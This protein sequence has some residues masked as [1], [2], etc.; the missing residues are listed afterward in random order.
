MVKI[1]YLLFSFIIIVIFF[2]LLESA[3]YFYYRFVYDK[4][5]FLTFNAANLYYKDVGNLLERRN[6]EGRED[7]WF[8]PFFPTRYYR[9]D[10]SYAGKMIEYKKSK[11]T[12]R[13]FSYGGSCTAGSPWGHRASFS[14]F[15]NDELNRIKRYGKVEIMN[16]GMGGIGSS[17]VLALVNETIK[18]KPDILLI[19]CGHNEC[20]DNYVHLKKANNKV[21]KFD[22][23]MR[24]RSYL[25]KVGHLMMNRL[26]DG[27]IPRSDLLNPK[28]RP[29]SQDAIY[30]T[31]HRK[32]FAAQ[33][34]RNMRNIADIASR[35]N[36]S[37]VF[38][39]QPS[40]FFFEPEFY[41]ADDDISINLRRAKQMIDEDRYSEA[42][43]YIAAIFAKDKEASMAHYYNGLVYLNEKEYGNAR[44]AFLKA[45]EYDQKPQRA[46][47]EYREIL[48]KLA[49]PKKG[50]YFVD[51]K[52]KFY[53]YLDDGL[54]DGRLIIDIVHPT[55]KGQKIIARAIL[56]DYFIK[57]GIREDML[58]YGIYEPEN[59]W[60]NNIDPNFYFKICNRYYGISDVSVCIERALEKS[61]SRSEQEKRI[62]RGLEEFQFYRDL[63]V[64]D[65]T[66]EVH[67][68]ADSQ[69][70]INLIN[71]GS[72]EIW[73]DG[74][75]SAPEGWKK[76]GKVIRDDENV[77]SGAYSANLVTSKESSYLYFDLSPKHLKGVTVTFCC[78]VRTS[79]GNSKVYVQINDGA[80]A[81]NSFHTG[82]GDW[83]F[84]TVTRT[85][86]DSATRV[87]AL[88]EI[89]GAGSAYFDDAVLSEGYYPK[90]IR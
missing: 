85:I 24:D 63:L 53:E 6:I 47:E 9:D 68:D 84:L 58:D 32:F 52:S 65:E 64:L 19:Y 72:F 74:D 67:I 49:S 62:A 86:D 34:E 90:G 38:I 4:N 31:Q 12:L 61:N 25:V 41:P 35:Y 44:E 79:V 89:N 20:Y 48:L 51:A 2:G 82:S 43:K 39:S 46:T 83:E 60:S 8:S 57:H 28:S 13:I 76:G 71:G 15:V 33:Y 23:L 18:Y 88:L 40:N 54:I 78:W 11:D 66:E 59:L 56:E 70:A 27:K 36:M 81:N 7:V 50:R 1:K 22:S 55:V 21:D 14:R 10:V 87:R 5:D 69:D 75:L 29:F 17:R 30:G 26:M 73:P 3:S 80:S 45:I 16:F 77:K 42:T 37:V